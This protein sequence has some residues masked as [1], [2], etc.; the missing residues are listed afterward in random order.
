MADRET[1]NWPELWDIEPELRPRGAPGEY[2]TLGADLKFIDGAWVWQG[3][4]GPSHPIFPSTALALCRDTARKWIERQGLVL[5]TAYDG[6]RVIWA[7]SRG[8]VIAPETRIGVFLRFGGE[9]PPEH[10]VC[11]C[12]TDDQAAH[13]LCTAILKARG[14]TAP[15]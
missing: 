2:D 4:W 15:G 13:A 8:A 10:H 14:L 3:S 6:S 1:P 7:A 11:N 12:A 5:V 9:L